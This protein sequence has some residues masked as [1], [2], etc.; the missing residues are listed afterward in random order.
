MLETYPVAILQDRYGGV[1][2]GG[3]WIAIAC[4]DLNEGEKIEGVQYSRYGRVFYSAM[5]GD[6]TAFRFWNE[7][8]G[9]D[10]IAMGSSPQE[11]LDRLR[12][13]A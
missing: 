7:Y 3:E 11:A 5:G 12:G 2:S 10:W 13:D 9:R 1:Y 8:K 6:S 4:A